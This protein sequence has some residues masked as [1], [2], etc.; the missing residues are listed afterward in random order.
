MKTN[1][2]KKLLLMLSV[3]F[4]L[5]MI[6]S[7]TSTYAATLKQP[8]LEPEAGWTRFDDT[9]PAIK[10]L[11][12]GWTPWK[13]TAS[14]D[15]GI[16]YND[17]FHVQLDNKDVSGTVKFNFTGTGVR[18]IGYANGASGYS[19]S[20]DILISVDGVEEHFPMNYTAKQARTLVFE[21]SGLEEGLHTV[22]LKTITPVTRG[23]NVD[24]IDI[25]G[26]EL[27]DIDV[28][29]NL[30]AKPGNSLVTLNWNPVEAA[31]SYVVRYGTE[32]GKYT[33]TVTATKD[34]YGN[35]VIPGLTNGTTYYFVVSAVIGGVESEYSNEASATP[36]GPVVE[37]EEPSGNRAILVVTMTTG[38]EKEFDLSMQE[39]NS[40]IDWCETKQ[41]GIGKASY[42]IDKHDNN[43]GPFKSRKDYIL[44]DRVLT[45]E[46]SEY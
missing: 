39:V 19:F 16:H 11:G 22:E 27:Q 10:F 2:F 26:G 17:T 9:D 37:P 5:T 34:E 32:P 8:L 44:F 41:A 12:T 42:A 29:M 14:G 13:A 3:L 1:Y 46:V 24:A 7:T 4:V 38:L 25:Q 18:I 21:K 45:F 30:N 35:F 43:K 28:P 36:Q 20:S 33:E 40:F 15:K 6:F 31:E 23:M